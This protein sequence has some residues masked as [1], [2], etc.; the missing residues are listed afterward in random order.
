MHTI[1]RNGG[2]LA[3]R[4]IPGTMRLRKWVVEIGCWKLGVGCWGGGG[5]VEGVVMMNRIWASLK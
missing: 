3:M 2:S 5:M 1:V 4:Y